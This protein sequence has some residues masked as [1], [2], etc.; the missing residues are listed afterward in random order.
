METTTQEIMKKY[1][2]EI[3]NL[4]Q[5][6]KFEMFSFFIFRSIIDLLLS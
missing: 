4:N 6:V 2:K 3:T 5:Q 1:E